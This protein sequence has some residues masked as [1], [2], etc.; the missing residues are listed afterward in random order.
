MHRGHQIGMLDTA[1]WRNLDEVM[2]AERPAIVATLIRVTGDWDL[3]EDCVQDALAK[4]LERWPSDGTP[5][6]M[7]AWLTTVARHR[8]LDVLRRRRNEQAKLVEV[9]I[10][11]ALEHHPPASAGTIIDDR[12][13][14]IFTCC[15]PALPL[16]SRVGLTLKTVAGLSTEQIAAAF[17]VSEKTMSQRILRAKR[18]IGATGI[19]FRTPPPHRLP[20]RTGAVLAVLYLIFNAGYRSPD[21]VVAAEALRLARLVVELLPDDTE[22]RGLLALLMFQHARRSGRFD[23]AGDLVPME[24]QDRTT[25]DRALMQEGREQLCLARRSDGGTAPYAH[26]A[27]IAACHALAPDAA[28]TDWTSI[29]QHYDALIAAHPSPVIALNRAI[30]IGF[31]HGPSAG[32]DELDLLTADSQFVGQHLLPAARADFLR[33]LGRIGDAAIAYRQ[34]CDLAPTV[35]DRR[36]LLRRLAEISD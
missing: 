10:A 3:A 29:V 24:E 33:R 16:E 36:F 1:P 18:K 27:A 11:G 22:A 19:G 28:A 4:A 17:L 30:A 7:A 6:N 5:R 12:L 9:A 14:L 15:H 13:R 8:A 26:Q 35:A 32:L 25:W 21:G 20:E 2:R 31:R 34:A 23:A